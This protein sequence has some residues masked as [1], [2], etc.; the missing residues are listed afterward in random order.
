[1]WLWLW[2]YFTSSTSHSV[3]AFW[4]VLQ[5]YKK[6]VAALVNR[7]SLMS[8]SSLS[9]ALGS[10]ET[11]LIREQ[12]T[13]LLAGVA[14][15]DEVL[16]HPAMLAYD[17]TGRGWHVFDFDPTVTTLRHRALPEGDD[18]PEPRR[19]SEGTGAPGYSGRKRGDIPCRRGTVQHAG[20]GVWVHAHLSEGNG[21]GVADLERGLDSIVE[22]CVRLGHPLSAALVRMDGEYGN[23]PSYTAC[24][25][26]GLPFITRLNRPKLFEDDE[27][28]ALLRA[29]TWHRVADSGSGPR[30]AAADLGMMTIAPGER[31]TR[32]DGT[33]Y[34]PI[35]VRVVAS[36]FPNTGEAGRGKVIDGWQVELFAADVP[37]DAWP[38]PEVITAY[39]GRI[40]EENRF[41]QEDRELGL[42]RL[43]SY[44]LPGQELATLV[45]LSVWNVRLVQGFLLERPPAERP[46]E[47]LRQAVVD[48]RVPT[49][50][51]RD[52]VLIERLAELDWA[53]MLARR[54]G[55]VWEAATGEILCPDG[56][57]LKLS[58]VR[59]GPH[60]PG[61]AGI[62]FL[63]PTGGCEECGPREGCL[64]SSKDRAAKHAEFS[65][66][67]DI[68]DR[69]RERLDLVRGKS[70]DD[71]HTIEP[72]TT[73]PGPLAVAGPRFLPARA[74]RDFRDCFLA[75]TLRIRVDLPPPEPPRPR[76]VA[77]DVGDRQR[78]RK[79]W[80]QNV[81][82]Y[83]LPVGTKVH[84]EVAGGAALRQ[85][86]GDPTCR[87]VAV[88]G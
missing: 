46:V 56:R 58:T 9:R 37:A 36:I 33:D 31:T 79:T 44:H 28:L 20:S 14:G 72:V 16:R 3:K 62:I 55:W 82:R 30:R 88:G 39:Y 63:R 21:K 60:G 22:T 59:R 77:V 27:V 57:A 17:A 48:D 13:W 53:S 68:A 6:Q 65:I 78:R 75:S 54:P 85:M 1:M 12:S 15:V 7:R 64:R 2:L 74:R 86:L 24:R 76:L 52:P 87:R 61:R 19:R 41:A 34:E 73:P 80:Q 83:A 32:P 50:W 71:A 43:V 66:P 42:D 49:H 70:E 29:A 84:V 23:V 25:E 47:V 5:P 26:R 51:P 10:V 18:L 81:D 67:A 35:T 45:G 69:L 38:A 11:G 8:P 4:E 40:G